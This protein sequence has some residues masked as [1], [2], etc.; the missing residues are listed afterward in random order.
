LLEH[1]AQARRRSAHLALAAEV[2]G[3]AFNGLVLGLAAWSEDAVADPKQAGDLDHRFVHLVPGL[4][5]RLAGKAERRGRHIRSRSN[6]ELHSLRKSLKRLRYGIEYTAKLY[7]HKAVKAYLRRCKDLQQI[8][9][10]INDTVAATALAESLGGARRAELA[11]AIGW[12]SQT[13]AVRRR[14]AGKGLPEA[15]SAFMARPRFW[16]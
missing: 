10:D 2:N 1:E 9:G 7:P 6:T 11:P 13:M 8:L 16:D 4:L 12:L 3:P 14:E 15:W 5:D